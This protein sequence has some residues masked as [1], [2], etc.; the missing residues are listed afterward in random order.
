MRRPVSI[1]LSVRHTRVLYRNSWK[2]LQT[3]LSAIAVKHFWG[4]NPFNR[5]VG[6]EKLAVFGWYLAISWKRYKIGLWLLW[7]VNRTRSIRVSSD[8]L[9]WPWKAGWEGSSCSWNLHAIKFGMVTRGKRRVC[10]GQACSPSQGAGPNFNL[11]VTPQL[12]PH[13]LR[14]RKTRFGMGRRF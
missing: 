5:G 12:T 11:E 1:C 7:S 6:S 2:Y 9:E 14:R 3:F 13:T 8:D 4:E 10:E